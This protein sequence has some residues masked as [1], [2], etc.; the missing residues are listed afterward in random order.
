MCDALR[1]IAD[2][3]PFDVMAQCVVG[4]LHGVTMYVMFLWPLALANH[5]AV[6]RWGR[7]E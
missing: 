4:T 7:V 3:Q 5:W 2:R 6:C 1:G